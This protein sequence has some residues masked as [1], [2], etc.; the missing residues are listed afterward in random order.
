MNN[1]ALI[2]GA[3]SGI[4]LD[5]AE[6]FAANRINLILVARSEDKLIKIANEL[7]KTYK[8]KA[9]TIAKD[10]SKENSA[11]EI[12]K[13]IKSKNLSI[14]YLINNAGFGSY[15]DFINEEWNVY[16]RMITLNI[17]SLVKLT[18]LFASEMVNNGRGK[19]LNVASTAGFQPIPGLNVYS[20]TKSFVISFSE[21]LHHEL[22]DKGVTVTTLCPGSTLT[23]FHNVAGLKGRKHI[24]MKSKT[25]AKIGY[26]AMM[27]GKQ[28]VIP[29]IINKISSFTVRFTPRRIIP[30]IS[31]KVIKGV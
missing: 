20:A 31:K 9:Y 2:T 23:N 17:Y 18:Y 22:I 11:L 25:V 10:L 14:E 8:I 30:I 4:G 21:A 5:L 15:K 12:Y 26:K 19:I 3:S 1:F 6:L 24:A 13:E 16:H 7:E 29:G 28:I 27:K